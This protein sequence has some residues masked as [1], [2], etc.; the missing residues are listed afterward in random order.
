MFGFAD[1]VSPE[2]LDALTRELANDIIRDA[3]V[4][5]AELEA[6]KWFANR[7]LEKLPTPVRE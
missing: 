4:L 3:D 2:V 7:Q 6:I 1:R 5:I